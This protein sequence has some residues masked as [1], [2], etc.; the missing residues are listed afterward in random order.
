VR[1]PERTVYEKILAAHLAAAEH[2]RLRVDDFLAELL[3]GGERASDAYAVY[4]Y[5]Q[6]RSEDF[7]RFLIAELGFASPE[8]ARRSLQARYGEALERRRQRLEQTGR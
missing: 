3:T 5:L 1:R 4:E 7:A 2:Q 8:Q 6:G